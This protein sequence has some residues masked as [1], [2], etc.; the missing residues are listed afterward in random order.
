M[1]QISKGGLAMDSLNSLLIGFYTLL[2]YSYSQR[3]VTRHTHTSWW[4]VGSVTL[5]ARKNRKE[6]IFSFSFSRAK[7]FLIRRFVSQIHSYTYVLRVV[8]SAT[9][10]EGTYQRIPHC[11]CY[12]CGIVVPFVSYCCVLLIF[13]KRLEVHTSDRHYWGAVSF[14][15]QTIQV[16]SFLF[17]H[18]TNVTLPTTQCHLCV[19]RW[20]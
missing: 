3:H 12:C 4:V 2:S 20:L 17:F 8:L 19:C 1:I 9:L 14:V 6:K 16:R 11:S 18:T 13:N 5:V 15:W 10:R 7:P